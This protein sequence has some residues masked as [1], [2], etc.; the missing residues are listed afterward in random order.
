M[1]AI[2]LLCLLTSVCSLAGLVAVLLACLVL[3]HMTGDA[4][5]L[6][7]LAVLVRAYRQ[8]QPA[9]REPA[10]PPIQADGRSGCADPPGG[11]DHCL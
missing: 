6:E 7:S 8:R 4:R 2:V 1:S 11:E 3:V 9:G 5:C 10:L